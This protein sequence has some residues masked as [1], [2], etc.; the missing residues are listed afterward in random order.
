MQRMLVCIGLHRTFRDVT[1]YNT[2]ILALG[3][4]HG[5][6]ILNGLSH[7]PGSD[8]LT[9]WN[10]KGGASTVDYLMGLLP[11]IPQ[12]HDFSISS[13]LIAVAADH[14]ILRFIVSGGCLRGAIRPS[15]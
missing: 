9:C 13:R 15:F 5:L 1:E 14:E 8:A 3:S 12:I 6:I 4:A 7:W 2:H 10:P 11:L